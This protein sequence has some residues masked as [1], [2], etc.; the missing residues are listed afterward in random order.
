[1]EEIS[2]DLSSAIHIM[3][4]SYGN[5]PII[6]RHREDQQLHCRLMEWGCI[7][8]YVKDEKTF[9][10]QRATMLN[11][12][13][14]RIL[15]DD[16][17]YWHKIRNRRCLIPISGFYEHRAIKGWKKKVPY[18]I[19]LK[20]Q[21]LFF[22]PGLYSVTELPDLETG[23]L[24]KRFTFTLITRNANAVMASIH[25]DGE[26][27][28]RM[29]L[30]LPFDLSRE[31]LEDNLSDDRYKA[32]LDYEMPSEAMEYRPV[33]TIRSPKARPDDKAKNEYWEWEKLPELGVG[34]P[35]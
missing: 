30:L 15:G 3:G 9:L 1:D 20:E 14:E 16:K 17:S 11:A 23:E 18:F 5:H 12:R 33:F 13:S 24:V 26:N 34:N 10:R 35:D 32:I 21:P 31:W 8:F 6:Y 2:L 28:G 29:P 27:R 19:H 25:N 4:H 7:P 22:L